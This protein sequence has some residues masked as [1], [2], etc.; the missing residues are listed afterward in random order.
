M[1]RLAPILEARRAAVA[2]AR[3]A[4]S[5]AA[6]L[7]RPLPA[8]RG[9]RRALARPGLSLVAEIKRASPSEGAIRPGADAAATAA[10]Y[11]AAGAVA[12]SVLT[13][14]RFFGGDLADLAAARGATHLPALRKD[15]VVD[16][17]QLAESRA[18][19][20]DAVL[21]IV[22]ALGPATG[23]FVAE[24]AALGLDALVEVHDEDELRIALDAGA[25]LVGINNRNL[26]DLSVDL[27]V[28]ERLAP[29]VPRGVTVV[30]ESGVERWADARRLARAGADAILVGTVLMKAPHPG[31][32]LAELI[33]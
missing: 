6:L 12:L 24:A 4:V 11:E 32:K 8:P 5:R 25:D 28:T 13:E 9:F 3:A 30:A 21:L 26:K 23:D 1:S 16:A 27:A 14:P 10:L 2:A 20:A 18:A 22:A 19:G 17:Y 29:L 15:F 7:D 33:G 31:A